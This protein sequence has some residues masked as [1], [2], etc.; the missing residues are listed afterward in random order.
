VLGVSNFFLLGETI[1]R[2]QY[3]LD[4]FTFIIRPHPKKKTRWLLMINLHDLGTYKSPAEAAEAAFMQNTGFS[5]W[6]FKVNVFVPPDLRKWEE[7]NP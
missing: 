4:D 7:I 6:D 5:A 1:L 3:K 2:Y